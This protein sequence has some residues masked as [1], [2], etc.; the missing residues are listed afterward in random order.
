[1]EV[2]GIDCMTD[3]YAREIKLNNLE[4]LK[5]E[6]KFSFIEADIMK[7]DLAALTEDRDFIFHLAAQPGVRGSWGENFSLYVVNNILST[8][9]LLEAAKVSRSLKKFIYASS[10]SVYGQIK[11]EAV[12]EA[13]ITAPHSPYGAT[14]LAGENLC[15]L[16]TANFGT[17]TVSLRLFTVYGPR[18]RPDMAFAKLIVA[19]LTGRSFPLF[20][21]GKQERDFTYVGDVTEAMV[22][23]AKSADAGGIFNVGGGHV[24]SMQE[25]IRIAGEITGKKIQIDS[26]RTEKGDVFRTSA[27]CSRAKRIFGFS[28]GVDINT[29]LEMQA[30]FLKKN[31]DL[32][33]RFI[34]I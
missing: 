21:D 11:E 12:S 5:R 7:T 10:S 20:G 6:A 26:R 23:A 14:K 13:R 4:T 24:V 34:P 1:M 29:G 28:P 3:Y 31:L 19:A 9:K 27:D 15:G 22:L 30:E 33:R 2:T 32:Y 18:Q 16:Y 8:Q 25:V 17:P